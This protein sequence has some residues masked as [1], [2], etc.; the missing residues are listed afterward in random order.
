MLFDLD[1]DGITRYSLEW[2]VFICFLI[3]GENKCMDTDHVEG[4]PDPDQ[5]HMP[6]VG[7]L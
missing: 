3:G 4:R 2:H 1:T 6:Q 5:I 7:K